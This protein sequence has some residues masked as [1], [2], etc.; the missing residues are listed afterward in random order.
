MNFTI[1]NVFPQS[2]GDSSKVKVKVRINIHGIFS[3]ASA[4]VIEKQNIEGDHSDIPMETETS[5]K[6]ES[7]DDV[8]CGNTIFK[9]LL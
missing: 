9:R 3:V 5:F 1:Q 6:N 7:K 8:V 4:S 2:D